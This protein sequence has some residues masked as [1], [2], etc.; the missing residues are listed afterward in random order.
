MIYRLLAD[1][2]VALHLLFVAFVILGGFAALRWPKLALVHIP[3]A[4]WGAVIEASGWTCPLT[5]LENSLRQAAGAAGYDG[6]FV[7]QYLL[8]IIY[9]AGL[10]RGIQLGLAALVVAVNLAVYGWLLYRRRR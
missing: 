4:C 9:P 1:A 6:S 2:V 8:P 3:A 5:P 7:E 10:T